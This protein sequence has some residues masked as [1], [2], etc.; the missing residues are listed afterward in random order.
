MSF[1]NNGSD[2]PKGYPN[3]QF[4]TT[5]SL[6]NSA[7][8]PNTG[9]G[10]VVPPN[11]AAFYPFFTQLGSDENVHDGKDREFQSCQFSFGNDLP[12]TTDDFGKDAQYGPFI[13]ENTVV[14]GNA[15]PIMRNPCTP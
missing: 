12:N 3:L 7:C 2:Q 1:D 15:G 13:A 5:I 14:F 9:A 8:N 4:K 11:G 6:S 10:C